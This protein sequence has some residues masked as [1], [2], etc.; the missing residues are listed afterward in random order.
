MAKI[1]KN[2]TDSVDYGG[3]ISGSKMLHCL[4]AEKIFLSME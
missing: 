2:F 4:K 1:N 3:A